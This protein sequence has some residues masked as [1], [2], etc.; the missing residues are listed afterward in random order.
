[1]RVFLLQ[2]RGS[3][4]IPYSD[5]LACL[6]SLQT[7]AGHLLAGRD[8]SIEP[9]ERGFYFILVESPY[10][11]EHFLGYLRGCVGVLAV[12]TSTLDGAPLDFDIV[13]NKPE[14][15]RRVHDMLLHLYAEHVAY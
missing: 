2:N 14:V 10:V 4:G 12:Q 8:A 11:A 3:R 5:A 13:M 9:D 1:M 6:D 7:C 15:W